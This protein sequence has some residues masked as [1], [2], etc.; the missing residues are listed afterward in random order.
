MPLF[1]VFLTILDY[2]ARGAVVFLLQG[3][4]GTLELA[5][6]AH[7]QPSAFVGSCQGV[8]GVGGGGD[9]PSRGSWFGVAN[10]TIYNTWISGSDVNS[11][12]C[13]GLVYLLDT[14]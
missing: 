7:A 2:D 8:C 14:W 11:F 4:L 6:V 3:E 13:D 10:T 1:S 9:A 5:S 12:C